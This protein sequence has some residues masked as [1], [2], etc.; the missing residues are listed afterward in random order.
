M[1]KCSDQLVSHVTESTARQFKKLAEVEG[2]TPSEYMRQL[3]ESHLAEKRA[4]FEGMQKVF[5]DEQN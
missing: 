4:W 3:I 1:N 2:T 5:G